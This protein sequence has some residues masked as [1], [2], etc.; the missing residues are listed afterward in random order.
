MNINIF[1]LFYII[2]V[3]VLGFIFLEYYKHFKLEHF[4]AIFLF[5]SIGLG[6]FGYKGISSYIRTK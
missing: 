2:L 6:Y 3:F 5:L 4:L 1:E